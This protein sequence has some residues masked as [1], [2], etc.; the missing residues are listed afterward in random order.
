M[1][2]RFRLALD[3]KNMG[4][5]STQLQRAKFLERSNSLRRRIENWRTLQALYIPGVSVLLARAAQDS[6]PGVLAEL[7][8]HMVLWLP[9]AVQGTVPCDVKLMVIEWRLR[10]AQSQDA[11]HDLRNHL[12]VQTHMW[13]KKRRDVRGVAGN[14]R[15]Q[16]ALARQ[17][18]KV[19]GSARKYRVA[20]KALKD[21]AEP[22]GMVAWEVDVPVLK[23][24][25]VRGLTEAVDGVSEGNRVLSWIWTDLGAAVQ[26]GD[27]PG[28]ND[29]E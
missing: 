2:F 26:A 7:P 13:K 22:L 16:N 21:L 11:L 24:T 1:L 4:P 23:P 27:D 20:R 18:E 15:A 9:S 19:D 29:G 25:D 8:Q 14:T 5:H 17:G 6:P 12:R 10:M 3:Q 28:L